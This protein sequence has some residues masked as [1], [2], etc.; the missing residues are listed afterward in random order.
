MGGP[1]LEMGGVGAIGI[2]RVSYVVSC[3]IVMFVL[4]TATFNNMRTSTDNCVFRYRQSNV[5]QLLP[6]SE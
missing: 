5:R 4:A 6:A 1:R 2:L 3:T